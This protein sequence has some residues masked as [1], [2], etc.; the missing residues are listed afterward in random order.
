MIFGDVLCQVP[1]FVEPWRSFRSRPHF[2]GFSS[3]SGGGSKKGGSS[4]S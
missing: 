1:I 2:A 3:S 4:P